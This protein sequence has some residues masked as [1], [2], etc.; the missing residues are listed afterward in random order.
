MFE[1]FSK[2]VHRFPPRVAAGVTVTGLR[3]CFVVHLFF[4]TV[5]CPVGGRVFEDGASVFCVGY[6]FAAFAG[7]A[8]FPSFGGVFGSFGALFWF[9]VESWC[10]T[11]FF[12]RVL[13]GFP[14]STL[15]SVVG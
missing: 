10:R 14:D 12:W 2:F 5:S 4:A 13:L 8:S 11:P 3:C 15:R 1:H 7:D 6:V 9:L